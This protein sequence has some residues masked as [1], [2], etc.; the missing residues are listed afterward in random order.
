[1]KNT[2]D[3]SHDWWKRKILVCA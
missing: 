3:A 2:I 1:M